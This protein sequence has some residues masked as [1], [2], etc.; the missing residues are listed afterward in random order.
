MHSVPGTVEVAARGRTE[1]VLTRR[2]DGD[3]NRRTPDDLIVEEPMSIRLD[4]TLVATTMRTPGDDFDLAVGFCVTEG[5]LGGVPVR[6]VRYCAEESA[7][8]SEFND[9]TVETG[10]LAPEPTPRMGPASSSCGLCGSLAIEELAE[11]LEPLQVEPFDLDLLAGLAD[12]IGGDQPLFGATGAVHSAVAFDRSGEPVVAREDIGRHNAVDK[13]VGHLHLN[14]LLPATDLG[15]WVSGR[16]SFELAQKAWA[17]GFAALI[18]VSAPSAL[19]VEMA[20]TA[21]FQLA[22]FARGRR[23]NLYTED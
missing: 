13:V 23:L 21:G 12:R 14:G 18:A 10:G 20:R 4:G 3:Q 6:G 2:I 9:V 1:R 11:R 5:V 16:A 22:G 7:T 8:E 17:A 15:L 19:A